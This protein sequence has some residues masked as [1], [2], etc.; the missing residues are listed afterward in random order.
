[1]AKYEFDIV[2]TC[3]KKDYKSQKQMNILN[4]ILLDIVKEIVKLKIN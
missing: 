3:Y 4:D 1:M 2:E